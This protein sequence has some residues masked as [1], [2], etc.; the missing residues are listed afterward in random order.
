MSRKVPTMEK[1]KAEVKAVLHYAQTADLWLL[2]R[3]G[4]TLMRADLDVSKRLQ[5][6]PPASE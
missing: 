6:M 1:L 5:S 2:K 3:S 4:L